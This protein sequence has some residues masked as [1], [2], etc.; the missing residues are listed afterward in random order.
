MKKTYEL[1]RL[2]SMK[3]VTSAP[4]VASLPKKDDTTYEFNKDNNESDWLSKEKTDGNGFWAHPQNHVCD[5]A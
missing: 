3:L 1:P 2:K 5:L 4:I